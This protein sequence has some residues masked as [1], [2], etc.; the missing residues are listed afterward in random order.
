MASNKSR[1][2]GSDAEIAVKGSKD[3]PTPRWMKD[4]GKG[5][6]DEKKKDEKK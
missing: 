5:K 1:F 2:T 4:K 6:K 3:Y